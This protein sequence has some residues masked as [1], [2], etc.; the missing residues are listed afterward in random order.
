MT[1]EYF[2]QTIEDDSAFPAP[3]LFTSQTLSQLTTPNLSPNKAMGRG[4]SA[5]EGTSPESTV[6]NT[7]LN[8]TSP[9]ELRRA[10]SQLYG[11]S[12]GSKMS[13]KETP[14]WTRGSESVES[15]IE[16]RERAAQ[17]IN[18]RHLLRASEE[19]ELLWEHAE[20]ET[21]E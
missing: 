14:R 21:V 4:S 19:E 1:L 16:A 9:G 17:N 8:G 5:N 10:G 15:E 12:S 6:I 11:T 2:D 18:E 7:S 3:S 13:H 20:E